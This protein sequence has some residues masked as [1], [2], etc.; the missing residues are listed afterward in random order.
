M[1]T[2]L[3][4]RLSNAD[5]IAANEDEVRSILVEELRDA[6]DD[7]I[8]DGLG[9]VIFHKKGTSKNPLKLMFCAHM[10]EVGFLVRSISNIGMVYLIA[11]GGVKNEAK[12]NQLVR[13]TTEDG[14]KIYGMLN[15]T[16]NGDHSQAKD[17]YVDLGCNNKEEVEALGIQ[18][19]DMV[20]FASE[21][22]DMNAD[23]VFAGKALDD[24]IGCFIL[25]ETLKNLKDCTCEHDVY[26]AMTSSEEVGVRGGETA[27]YTIN[28]DLVFAVDV[29]NAPDLVRDHTNQRKIGEGCMLVHYDKS[30]AANKK[31]LSYLKKLA[32]EHKIP[33]QCDMFSGG[34]TDAGKAHLE[35]GGRPACVIGIPL[36]FCHGPYSML[37]KN[38]VTH[39]ITFLKEII[40]SM[41]DEIYADVMNYIGGRK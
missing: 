39:T 36:R 40:S 15:S 6:C 2:E 5:A 29:A 35:R 30:M 23:G 34:G 16:W 14:N 9:S 32:N 13:I 12:S 8:T 19:G 17:M 33:Y 22:R 21:A 26:F 38:D 7:I 10:D 4:K 24:R 25:A 31:L 37:H 11:A 41:N 28:P 18:I 1:N 3:L 20:T 27:T